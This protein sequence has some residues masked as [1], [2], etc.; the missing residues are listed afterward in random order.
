MTDSGGLKAQALSLFG[1]GFIFV[2]L[3]LNSC[4]CGA[5][6]AILFMHGREEDWALIFFLSVSLAVL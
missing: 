6:L 5:P 4:L 3:L 2:A 1:E